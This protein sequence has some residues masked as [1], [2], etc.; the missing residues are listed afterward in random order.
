MSRSNRPVPGRSS[1]RSAPSHQLLLAPL[2]LWSGK[3]TSADSAVSFGT[4]AEAT[5]GWS[6]SAS[7]SATPWASGSVGHLTTSMQY[8]LLSHACLA[9]EHALGQEGDSGCTR[10]TY[11]TPVY[12][13]SA[14]SVVLTTI[15]DRLI[16]TAMS[17]QLAAMMTHL[18]LIPLLALAAAAPASAELIERDW[19]APGDGLLTFNPATGREWLDVSETSL[20]QFGDTIDEAVASA[21][22]EL[23]PGGRFEGFVLA[24][25]EEVLELIDASGFDE[26]D[27][28]ATSGAM[29]ELISL[30]GGVA[31]GV[32]TEP[33]DPIPPGARGFA[34]GVIDETV[35]VPGDFGSENLVV[36]LIVSS[37][38]DGGRAGRG[39]VSF[40]NSQ[41]RGPLRV[42]SA[43]L[44]LY[45]VIV[46][47]PSG[48]ALLF[49]VAYVL[50]SRRVR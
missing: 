5:G 44:M 20:D 23:G 47:E 33:G 13:E 15:R 41:D 35:V 3:T 10:V 39:Q 4:E 34:S 1:G 17:Q 27:R 30:L 11:L 40:V 25:R 14:N 24:D 7:G 42:S 6:G 19:L 26:L 49:P 48:L 32:P 9:C 45:R 2:P 29:R 46:P 43:G 12:K 8:R 36:Q 31:V 37:D 28:V 22:P 50:L 16:E 38:R 18:G 21:K